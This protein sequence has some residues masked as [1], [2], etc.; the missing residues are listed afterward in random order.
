MP[1][2]EL[3]QR[4]PGRTL[5]EVGAAVKVGAKIVASVAFGKLRVENP[6]HDVGINVVEIRPHKGADGCAN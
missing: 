2:D 3:E 1:L 5:G 6:H 4:F